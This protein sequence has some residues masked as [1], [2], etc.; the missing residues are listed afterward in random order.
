MAGGMLGSGLW[1][2]YFEFALAAVRSGLVI[3]SAVALALVGGAW[4]WADYIAPAFGRNVD[5]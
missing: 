5:L 2:L 1:L 3:A 4:L